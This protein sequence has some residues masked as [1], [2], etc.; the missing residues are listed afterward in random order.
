MLTCPVLPLVDDEQT[1]TLLLHLQDQLHNRNDEQHAPLFD[2]ANQAAEHP[3]QVLP[4]LLQKVCA[5]QQDAAG[6][7]LHGR[8]DMLCTAHRL[9]L[10]EMQATPSVCSNR[11]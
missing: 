4:M 10:L 2:I 3:G 1:A 11:C 6:C 9:R 8:L 7:N 5:S